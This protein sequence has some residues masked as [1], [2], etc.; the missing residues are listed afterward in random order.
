MI[1]NQLKG[2]TE[3]S[4]LVQPGYLYAALPGTKQNGTAFVT[5]AVT[6]GASAL[7]LPM[8]FDASNIPPSVQCLFS[9]TPRHDFALLCAQFYTQQPAHLVGVTGTSGKTSVVTMV[10]QIWRALGFNAGTVGTLGVITPTWQVKD[11]TMTTPAPEKLFTMLQKMAA[12]GTNHVAMEITSHALAQHR[13]DGVQL[14]A[15]AFTNLSRDHLDY[16]ST[17]ETY[18]E[19]KN[20]LFKR[21]LPHGYPAI[22]NTDDA[23]GLELANRLP[24]AL[25]VG[26]AGQFIKLLSSEPTATGQIVVL[27][28][29]GK[30]HT[31]N[32]P[33]GGAFQAS[34]ALVAIGLVMADAQ[35]IPLEKVVE[36]ASQITGITGR[37]EQVHGHKQGAKIY[38]DYAH[39]PDGLEQVLNTLRPHTKG[40]LICLFGCGGDRDAGKRPIM[41]EIATR[42]ADVVIVTDDNP[43]TENAAKIRADVLAGAPNAIEIGGRDRAIQQAVAMLQAGDTLLVAGKGHETYQIIGDKT[44]PFSDV[45]HVKQALADL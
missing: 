30:P 1:T 37:L 28:F 43:R 42:L 35:N 19:A 6:R 41:G 3:D 15:A 4:R 25:S 29:Q 22:I 14:S 26:R 16:H 44:F 34:N 18:F 39:K 36:A 21:I 31:L 17:M 10:A 20:E 8:G 2:L 27:E 38:V 23:F 13:V 45:E 12:S 9:N 5:D 40:Q 32:L 24:N 7:L 11:D 33:L